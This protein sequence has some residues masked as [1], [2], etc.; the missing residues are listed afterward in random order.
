SLTRIRSLIADLRA[1]RFRFSPARRITIPKKSGGLR[2]LGLPNFRDKLVQEALRLLLEAYYEPR[3]RE[4]SH[5]FRAGRGCHTALTTVSQQFQGSAWFIEGDIRAC[6]DTIDHQVL[7]A[8]LSRDINDGRLLNLIRMGLAAGVL[9]EWTYH[10]T[11]SGTPQ[12]GVLSPLLANIYL[13]ELDVFIEDT[14][15]PQYHRGRRRRNNPPYKRL[16]SQLERARA[17]GDQAL[18]QE[19]RQH[20]VTLPAGDPDDPDYRRLSYVRYA[21]DFVLG[22]AGPKEEACAIKTAIGTFLREHLHLELSAEKT[23]ITHA[24]TEQAR[25]LG[26]SVSI[27]QANHKQTRRHTNRARVRSINGGVRLGLPPGLI[28]T[29]TAPYQ[30]G[31]KP[32]SEY[33][34]VRWSDAHIIDTYQARYR[35]LAEYYKVAADR[36]RLSSVKNVM[37]IALVKTLAHK[38]RITVPQVYR[39]YRGTTK[40][41]GR[42]YRTLQVSIPT[43]KGVRTFR[44]GG[45]SLA[46][47]QPGNATINDIRQTD[48]WRQLRS[49][50][51][52][53]LQA[54]TCELCGS[55]EDIQ[56]HHVRKLAD[57]KR[58]WAGRR[59]KPPWVKTIIALRRKTLVVCR[60][61]HIAIHAGKPT[62]ANRSEVL[63][64]RVN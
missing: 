49:D 9:D 38:F 47:Q 36:S 6:F 42:E 45:I 13:H 60:D 53:R 8:I 19:L 41:D 40:V 39:K 55:H 1:E 56:V 57:L 61:C 58:R 32:V 18:A 3:F 24:R 50:L 59:A 51:V 2:S 27:Y 4:S 26:Y 28:Q 29:V 11:Y 10:K 35:G 17:N 43:S 54:D 52:R 48:A 5:G 7:L 22:F 34:L 62:P 20:L 14:L 64:S 30:Q 23:L 15:I 63:E 31:N 16:A 21:D 33:R 46:A 37:Q 12:G 44:W 25:F